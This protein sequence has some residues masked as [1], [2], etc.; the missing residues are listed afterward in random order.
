MSYLHYMHFFDKGLEG[1]LNMDPLINS[2]NFNALAFYSDLLQYQW[3][4]EDFLGFLFI[5]QL[6]SMFHQQFSP[7]IIFF[8]KHALKTVFPCQLFLIVHSN[9]S[10]YFSFILLMPKSWLILNLLNPLLIFQ[11]LHFSFITILT[12]LINPF[13]NSIYIKSSTQKLLS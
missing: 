3:I 11:L 5:F 1:N 9:Q 6:L 12:F 4:Y 13:P 10:L 8:L 7:L 2:F